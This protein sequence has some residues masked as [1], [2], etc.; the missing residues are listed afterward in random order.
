MIYADSYLE[1]LLQAASYVRQLPFSQ[2]KLDQEAFYK[3][4][5]KMFNDSE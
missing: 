1:K 2:L 5:Q 4:D 3:T